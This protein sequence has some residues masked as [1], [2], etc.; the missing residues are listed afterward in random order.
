MRVDFKK[1]GGGE[2]VRMMIMIEDS[3]GI[4]QQLIHLGELGR[5]ANVDGTITDF[6]DE[7]T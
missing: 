7:T 5:D 4:H 3:D 2:R 1:K 6:D